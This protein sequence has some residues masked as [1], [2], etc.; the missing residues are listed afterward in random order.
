M[1]IKELLETIYSGVSPYSST[2]ASWVDEGYPHT[3][4]VPELIEKM[5][6]MIPPRYIVEFG[7]M[8]G[9]SAIKMADVIEKKG[10]E[11]E[12][13]CVDPF[14]GDINM[15]DWEKNAEW[16]FLRLTN[17]VPTIYKRFLA[18]CRRRGHEHRILPINTTTMIG[19]GL[20]HRLAAQ[21]RIHDMPNYIYL[22]SAHLPEETFM[23]LKASWAL[24]P[25]G[26][27][28]FGDDW[29]WPAVRTD[30]ER[31]SQ[32]LGS[33]IDS[34]RLKI[35]SV[36]LGSEIQGGR[37]LLYKG[38]WVLIKQLQCSSANKWLAKTVA[39]VSLR[40]RIKNWLLGRRQA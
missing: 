13:I 14:V 22:D 16:K 28:L 10:L 33:E 19:A 3:N 5:F 21:G 35:L 7:S 20:L 4:I 32:T 23:E 24:L 9:G 37:I 34:D 38:Q 40:K 39:T 25:D 30:V 18:N 8:L 26:G 2:D 1:I 12:I 15:W 36:K 27:V 11:A 6:E 31:F 17:G 29:S